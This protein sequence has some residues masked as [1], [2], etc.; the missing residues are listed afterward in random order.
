MEWN[1]KGWKWMDWRNGME[2][3]GIERWMES[4]R[5]VALCNALYAMHQIKNL[6]GKILHYLKS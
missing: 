4:I 6:F 2:W 1:G 5:C 3:N